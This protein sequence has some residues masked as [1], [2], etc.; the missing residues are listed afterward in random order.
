M[1]V[2]SKKYLGFLGLLVVLPFT[3]YAFRALPASASRACEFMEV[4][5]NDVN[6]RANNSKNARIIDTLPK[7]IVVE[8]HGWSQDGKWADVSTQQYQGWVFANYLECYKK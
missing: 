3:S 5:A 7:G 2:P 8:F 4:T 6:M 1:F